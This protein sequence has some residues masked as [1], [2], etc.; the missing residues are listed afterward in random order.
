MVTKLDIGENVIMKEF[1]KIDDKTAGKRETA[2]DLSKFPWPFEKDTFEEIRAENVLEKVDDLEAVMNEVFRICKNGAKI[3][4]IVPY[5]NSS[6][7]CSPTSHHN[8]GFSTFY[9]FVRGQNPSYPGPYFKM[10]NIKSIPSRWFKWIPNFSVRWLIRHRNPFMKFRDILSL[11]IGEINQ[12]L[13]VE[14]Q[15]EDKNTGGQNE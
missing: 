8:F 9:Y 4:I 7:N 5:F 1:L 10:I 15:V 2:I 11:F 6:S 3:Y 12:Y 14:L 13:Y